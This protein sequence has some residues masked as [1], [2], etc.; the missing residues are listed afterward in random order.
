MA[1]PADREGGVL[2]SGTQRIS[3]RCRRFSCHPQMC[4]GSPT[5]SAGTQVSHPHC[6]AASPP[7]GRKALRGS[8][9]ART[10]IQPVGT[11]QEFVACLR[12]GVPTLQCIRC[13]SAISRSLSGR[14]SA[15]GV[16][17]PHALASGAR[18]PWQ[19]SAVPVIRSWRSIEAHEIAPGTDWP[20]TGEEGAEALSGPSWVTP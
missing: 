1:C 13:A 16:V 11:E 4:L 14:P 6:R 5:P 9:A 3:G 18:P 10:Q 20:P 17:K 8:F 19:R 15:E 12:A 7:H 2:A